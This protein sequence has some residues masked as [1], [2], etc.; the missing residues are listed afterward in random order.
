MQEREKRGQAPTYNLLLLLLIFYAGTGKAGQAPTYNLLLL[1]LI[2]Y[3]GTGKA[4][5]ILIGAWT[6]EERRCKWLPVNK[7]KMKKACIESNN[8][9]D[10]Y[11]RG[12]SPLLTSPLEKAAIG[13]LAAIWLSA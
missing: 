9:N 5:E 3:A 2:F 7:R 1:L 12:L 4:G 10:L 13:D 6:C 8:K 11:V